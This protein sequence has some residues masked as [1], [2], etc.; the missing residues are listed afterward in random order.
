VGFVLGAAKTTIGIVHDPQALMQT[1]QRGGGDGSQMPL[2][3]FTLIE[4][5]L[6]IAMLG[7]FIS[8]L[9]VMNSNVLGLLRNSKDNVSASQALQE[10][11]EQM[12]IAN[13]VQI[14]D[15][16]Y[17]KE[18]L[19]ATSTGSAS[20]LPDATETITVSA[21]PAK[22]GASVRVTRSKNAARIDSLNTALQQERMVRV[23][24]ELNWEGFPQKRRRTRVATAIIAKGGI[25]K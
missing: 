23:D 22:A 3:G 13:W 17:L 4:T 9:L 6:A 8:M 10:R 2:A 11:V 15:T 20:S 14:S 1:P 25:T 12:R 19:L 24:V 5:T 16:D 18:K 7:L 21:Y